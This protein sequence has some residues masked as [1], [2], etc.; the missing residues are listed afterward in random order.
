MSDT[1]IGFQEKN[2][3][4]LLSKSDV[5]SLSNTDYLRRNAQS[6]I[7]T[8]SPAS[9][10]AVLHQGNDAVNL[11]L[12]S[13]E[14]RTQWSGLL[15]CIASDLVRHAKSTTVRYD[16]IGLRHLPPRTKNQRRL[17]EAKTFSKGNISQLS[18]V[19]W[20]MWLVWI[21]TTKCKT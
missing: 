14:I 5:F 20:N 11:P 6:C 15:T 8:S 3:P 9:G 4:K 13:L 7:R 1:Q 10:P 2:P 19:T 18:W 17:N 12:L 21:L 16:V